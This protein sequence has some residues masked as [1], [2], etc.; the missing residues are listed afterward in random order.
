MSDN[1]I[2][3]SVNDYIRDTYINSNYCQTIQDDIYSEK[4]NFIIYLYYEIV[5]KNKGDPILD[6]FVL[7]NEV[8]FFG[9]SK[10]GLD[11]IR[12]SILLTLSG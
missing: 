1:K 4:D 6:K 12:G 8:N 2:K 5:Q 3:M 10:A 9:E 11:V 7:C